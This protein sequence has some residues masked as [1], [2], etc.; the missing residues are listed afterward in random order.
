M[1]PR[2]SIVL[3]TRN[4]AA[5]LAGAL[6]SV[7]RQTFSDWECIVVD[8]GSSDATPEVLAAASAA[9]A[10]VRGIRR[11]PGGSAAAARNAALGLAR[12]D[13]VAFLDDDDRWAPE[14]LSLQITRLDSDPDALLACARVELSGDAAGVW[15]RRAAPE[16]PALR[17]L[18]SSN[19]IPVSTVM[20]RRS[21]LV[22]SGG[23][24]E[25]LAVAEDYDLWIRIAIDGP[26]RADPEVLARYRFDGE[27]FRRQ[28]GAEIDAL[29]AI[30]S[31]AA[32]GGV[33]RA[34]LRP[35][36]RRIHRYRARH[37]PDLRT[38]VA[39]WRRAIF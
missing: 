39:E 31:R 4:R 5:V 14:K 7:R 28:R 10:R 8:D 38:A 16:H 26:I 12:G 34:W 11:E 33:P 9:D 21:A 35:A 36:R 27:R 24:D 1:T 13:L 3:P 6:D 25:R 32:A 2:V 17:R 22:R 29:D 23:F 37:A 18:L 15:P 20:A 19:F 30:V